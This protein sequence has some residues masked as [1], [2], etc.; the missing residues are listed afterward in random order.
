MKNKEILRTVETKRGEIK[1]ILTHKKIKN[2]YIRVRRDCTVA[3]SAP[4][5]VPAEKTDEFVISR[6]EFIFK[7]IKSIV[8][9][10]QYRTPVNF[11]NDSVF[12]FLGEELHLKVKADS[13]DHVEAQN[14]SLTVHTADSNTEHIQKIIEDWYRNEC[15]KI[16]FKAVSEI[17][18]IFI[19]YKVPMPEITIQEMTSRWGSCNPYKNKMTLNSVLIKAPMSCIEYVIVHEFCHYI[20]QDH[21]KD[22]YS[23]MQKI[24][25]DWKERKN[26]LEEFFLIKNK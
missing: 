12:F 9:A 24:L 23:F 14:G 18:Q 5:K 16:F 26:M 20:H 7:A 22:F 25:P 8:S 1:Y 3:V 15:K 17:H 4:L 2:I 21:S 13:I 19:S 11:T 10:A 6:C